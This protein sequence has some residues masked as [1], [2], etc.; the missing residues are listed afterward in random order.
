VTVW[1]IAHQ[2]LL[3]KGV[4]REEYW[5]GLPFT[6]PGDLPDPGIK[7]TSLAS[8]ALAD[9]LFTTASPGKSLE[10]GR[11]GF[12]SQHVYFSVTTLGIT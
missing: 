4:S 3:S 2:A 5:S 12:K 11:S 1:T 6:S 8:P 7:P 9:R 10:P